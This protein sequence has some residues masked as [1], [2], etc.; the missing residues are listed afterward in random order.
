MT[1]LQRFE[2][3]TKTLGE[4]AAFLGADVKDV[5]EDVEIAGICSNSQTIQEGELFLALPGAK[6]HGGAFL[7]SAVERGA[8]AVLT[9]IAGSELSSV[10]DSAIPVLVVPNPRSQSGYLADWFNESPSQNMYLAGITGT[11]GKTTTT[12]LL[13]QIWSE[14]GFES[15]LMGTIGIS[16]GKDSFPA[17]HTTPEADV[18]HAVLSVMNERHVRVAA[19]EVS[20]HAIAQHRIDGVRFS[21]AGFTNLSQDHLDFHGTMENYYQAKRALFEANIAERGFINIDNEFG[22]RLTKEIS[23][24]VATLSLSNKK[25][26]WYFESITQRKRGWEVSIRGEGGVLIEGQFNLPGE[27]NLENL[28]LAVAIATDSGIDPLVIGN[29]MAKLKGAPGRLESIE[30]GQKFTALVDYAHTPD[31]VERVLQSL[32]Q[33]DSADSSRIIGVVGCG[34]NRDVAKR[35][36]MGKA[37]RNGSDIAIF[38]SDNPR[39]EEPDQILANMT[40][41]MSLDDS[42]MVIVDRREAIA[43]AIATAN[44]GDIVI[45]LGKGHETGQEIKGVKV[46]FDD[47][48]ELARAIE[49]LT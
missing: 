10:R 4:I 31:A 22:V 14:A 29:S 46:P 49:A 17:S 47:R 19:M 5:F 35:P 8:R 44:E 20:S 36:L 40:E 15:G 48:E 3:N 32:K 28:L 24:P 42:A 18:V 23:I 2:P 9:D 43:T 21:A 41:G 16:V 6:T 12:Y 1:D 25:A 37:L 34:G 27:H 7:P 30:R 26:T 38:T 45:V 39:D 13:N 11:N 33:H